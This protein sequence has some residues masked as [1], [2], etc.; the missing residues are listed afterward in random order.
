MNKNYGIN[1]SNETFV[2]NLDNTDAT[3]ELVGGKGASLARLAAADF[4]G[5]AIIFT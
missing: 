5:T 4:D 3:L 2:L 1:V